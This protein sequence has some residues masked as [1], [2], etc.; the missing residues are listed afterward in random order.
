[1]IV[2]IMQPAYLPW[3]GYFERIA[4]SDLHIVLDHVAI[5]ANS[6]T[7]F[8]NRNK[9]RT[10]EGW[11]WLTV[12]LKSKGKHG[13]LF[14]NQVEIGDDAKW[15]QKHW[16]TLR[17]NYARAPHFAAHKEFFEGVFARSW[18]KLDDLLR[19]TTGYLRSSLNLQTPIVFSSELAVEGQKDELI[20]NLCRKVGATTYISG[21]F[22]RDYLDE[23]AFQNEKI[24]IVYHEYEHPTYPQIFPGFEPYMSAVD[25]LLNCGPESLQ[26]LTKGKYPRQA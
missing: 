14:L 11:C 4:M 5:D 21:P 26:I 19:E 20:L 18:G 23:A 1:M 3:L 12:P 9:I 24:E 15:A 7:K 25:L 2:S 16:G 10:P 13:E 17:V 6:K 8:A 22:G